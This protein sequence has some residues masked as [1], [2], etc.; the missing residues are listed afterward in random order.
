MKIEFIVKKFLY[1][2]RSFLL[3]KLTKLPKNNK[4]NIIFINHRFDQ[5]IRSIKKSFND[6]NVITID[7]PKVFAFARFFFTKQVR[8]LWDVCDLQTKNNNPNGYRVECEKI[9]KNLISKGSVDFLMYPSDNYFW[10]RE[11]IKVAKDNKIPCLVL[12]K[13]GTISPHHFETESSRIRK[14]APFISD[15]IFVWSKRQKRYWEHAGAPE[16]S[17]HVVGQVRSDLLFDKPSPKEKK[18]THNV[19]FFTYEDTAYIPHELVEKGETWQELK[20]DTHELLLDFA[21]KFPNVFFVVK[22]HPQQDDLKKIQKQMTRKNIKVIGGSATATELIINADIVISFQSTVVLESLLL[23]KPT[24]YTD[25]TNLVQATR[26]TILPFFDLP[27]VHTSKSKENLQTV[28]NNFLNNNRKD[29][30]FSTEEWKRAKE[31]IN[32][33]IENADGNVSKRLNDLLLEL[34]NE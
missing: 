24:I 1:K 17:I 4:K 27:C 15:Q 31:F 25:W 3:I 26:N 8:D 30:N 16:N 7:G 28:L 32:I 20:N 34:F 9:L 21:R 13:E 14:Y 11:F 12:D 23:K 33:Y 2:V 29:F 6:F 10:I 19:L 18:Y 5:D 22:A